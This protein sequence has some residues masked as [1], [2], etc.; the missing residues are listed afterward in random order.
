MDSSKLHS[1]PE[2]D[3]S[4][5]QSIPELDLY[6]FDIGEHRRIHKFLG[7]HLIE[8]GVRFAVWAPNA[9]RVS[10][11]GSFNDWDIHAHSMERRGGTGVWERFIP[12]LPPR[13]VIERNGNVTHKIKIHRIIEVEHM[14]VPFMIKEITWMD[15]RV[16]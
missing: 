11:V 13:C 9:Q 14:N 7:A 5:L 2:I 15:V 6:L 3:S 1:M 10:V 4:K 12:E 16:N 8:G